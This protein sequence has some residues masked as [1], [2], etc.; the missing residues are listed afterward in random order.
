MIFVVKVW[1][2]ESCWSP[3]WM[4]RSS[5]TK[6]TSGPKRKTKKLEGLSQRQS[7]GITGRLQLACPTDDGRQKSSWNQHQ[8][9]YR[10]V[11]VFRRSTISVCKCWYNVS[12]LNEKRTHE[13]SGED[14]WI[15]WHFKDWRQCSLLSSIH[16]DS[17]Y[18]QWNGRTS[19]SGQA[20]L[21]KQ[22]QAVSQ[23]LKWQSLS[24][25]PWEWWWS[26]ISFLFMT[27]LL[28]C[29]LQ[30]GLKDKEPQTQGAFHLSELTG[31]DI[32]LVMRIL[33]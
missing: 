13:Y 25:V 22:L 23:T 33:L 30:L 5:Q 31:Q 15:T 9:G 11:W 18:H 12:L 28:R 8:R 16:N 1:L 29:K 21:G 4:K 3:L 10:T 7:C 26:A 32:S 17:C 6:W 14:W 2:E 24:Q 27:Y 20:T 19:V